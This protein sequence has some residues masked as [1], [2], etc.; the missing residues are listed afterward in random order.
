[1]PIEVPEPVA[2]YFA[3]ERVNDADALARCFVDDGTVQDEGRTIHGPAAIRQWNIDARD[4]Y[5]HTVEPLEVREEAGKIIVI[6]RVSGDFPG[7]PVDLQHVF[8]LR[9]GKIASLEIR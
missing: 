3:A 1:M 5:H 7:S 4:K 8:Q 6:G 2:G 9:G